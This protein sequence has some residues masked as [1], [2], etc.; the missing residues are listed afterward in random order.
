MGMS[1]GRCRTGVAQEKP[2]Y[3]HQGSALDT[4]SHW[5]TLCPRPREKLGIVLPPREWRQAAL[6]TCLETPSYVLQGVQHLHDGVVY[7]WRWNFL[8]AFFLLSINVSPSPLYVQ[9]AFSSLPCY[10]W[11]RTAVGLVNN[12]EQGQW[13]GFLAI[14]GLQ[15]RLVAQ[16]KKK[17]YIYTPLYM[18]ID[19][20]ICIYTYTYERESKGESLPTSLPCE[21]MHIFFWQGT[22]DF[23]P[24][25]FIPFLCTCLI[26][27]LF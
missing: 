10:C 19:T 11:S 27:S 17:R 26:L 16:K 4:G 18:Y 14:L 23:V 22:C 25:H 1:A 8:H 24:A 13:K 7:L 20:Y 6:G 3:Q 12:L 2:Q 5:N 21:C 9:H 15:G